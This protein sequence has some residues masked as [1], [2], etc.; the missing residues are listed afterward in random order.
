MSTSTSWS[1]PGLADFDAQRGSAT[2]R[3][4]TTAGDA[5]P[6]RC[7]HRRAG[8]SQPVVL[9]RQRIAH[10]A[11]LLERP[12]RQGQRELLSPHVRGGPVR[13]N[14]VEDCL[15]RP[16]VRLRPSVDGHPPVGPAL[17]DVQESTDGHRR[18]GEQ[19]QKRNRA[20][21]GALA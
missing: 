17:Q 20:A 7:L 11:T 15:S 6:A 21:K 12:A 9:G 19:R 10:L 4:V 3:G 5:A 18:N 16:V 8:W 13:S 2:P 14:L 1:T